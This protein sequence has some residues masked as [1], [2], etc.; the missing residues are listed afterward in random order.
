MQGSFK[1]QVITC[2]AAVCWRPGE[3]LVIQEVEVAPPQASE[4]RIKIICS[5]LCHTDVALWSNLQDN[6]LHPR[7]Y[8]HEAV[9]RVESIGENVKDVEEGDLVIPV[10]QGQCTECADCKSEKSNMCALYLPAQRLG[11]MKSDHKTRFSING[12]PVYHVL[13]VSSFAEYTVVDIDNVVKINPMAAPDKACLLSCGIT[14]GLGGVWKVGNVEKGSTVAIFGLGTVGLAAAQGA[15]IRGAS[16]IIGVD[17]N[18]R[19]FEIGRKLGVTD[20]VNPK[21]HDEPVNEIIKKMTKGGVDYSF[22]C[23]GNPSV[24]LEA[25]HSIR[26]GWGKAVVLSVTM[27]EV[28]IS[29]AALLWGKSITGSLLGGM[30]PKT[31]IPPLVDMYMKKELQLDDYK[32]HEISFTEINKAFDLLREG[33]CLRCVIWFDAIAH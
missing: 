3:P 17:V 23:S 14:T 2:K 30:K 6:S 20:F 26:H 28:P 15:R 16:K 25:F 27:T 10:F 22:E 4:V 21:D 9:G 12:E 24:V 33:E 13:N 29:S 5:S 32:T 11:V 7:I 18:P 1:G 8:G 31:D 19:K